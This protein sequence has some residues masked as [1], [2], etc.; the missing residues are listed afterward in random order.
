M[1]KPKYLLQVRSYPEGRFC[2]VWL[3]R[4]DGPADSCVLY[5][6]LIPGLAEEVAAA[7]GLPLESD[8][9][10]FVGVEPIPTPGCVPVAKQRD[11]FGDA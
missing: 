7:L 10:P 11:L 1:A 4:R 6:E 3:V 2:D 8:D 9:S 5:G